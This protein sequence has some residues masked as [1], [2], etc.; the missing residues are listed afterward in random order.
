MGRPKKP[1]GEA[2]TETLHVRLTKAE[3]DLIYSQSIRYGV[4]TSQYLRLGLRP[5]FDSA[6]FREN[7]DLEARKPRTIWDSKEVP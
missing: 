5:L 3:A 6:S 7:V 1:D 2:L 4:S